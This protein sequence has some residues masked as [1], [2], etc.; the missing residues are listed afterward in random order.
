MNVGSRKL[1]FALDND[2]GWPP[3]AS[4][5]VWCDLV[6]T[7]FQLKNAPF[8]IKSLAVNDVFTAEEDPVNGHIFEFKLLDPSAHS[9]VWVLNNTQAN[10]DPFLAQLRELGCSTEGL[11]S[12]SLYAIDV[13]PHVPDADL[14][15]L[16]DSC[17]SAGF[18]LAF[19]VWRRE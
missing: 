2:D 5:A 9:L 1:Q 6:G 15:S 17:E 7:A 10:I 11:A 16:L 12:F 14:T 13:P 19:P 18:S 4:E 3:V 8:F